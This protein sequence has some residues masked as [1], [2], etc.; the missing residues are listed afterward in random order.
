MKKFVSVLTLIVIVAISLF[1]F[2]A[3][4]PNE[5]DFPLDPPEFAPINIKYEADASSIIPLFKSGTAKF[6]VIGEPAVTQLTNLMKTQNVEV[7]NLFD[8]QALWKSAVNG[9]SEGYPQASVIVK[10]SLLANKTF[11]DALANALSQNAEYMTVNVA[12][13]GETLGTVGSTLAK[14]TFNADLIKRCNLGFTK[15]NADGL[16]KELETYLSEFGFKSDGDKPNNKMPTSDFYYDFSATE[17]ADV[18]QKVTI[19]APDGAPAL[20]LTKII[21]DGKI[22]STEVEVVLTTGENVIAKAKSGE[23]DIAVLPT[24]AA[25]T[26]FNATKGNYKLFSVNVFGVLYVVGTEKITNLS[27]LAGTTVYS[28]GLGNTPEYVFKRVLNKNGLTYQNAD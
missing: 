3:C 19:Y 15:A 2:A 4:Q 28:I 23:A 1:A 27:D 7:Y 14:T 12:T 17:T 21:A 10:N 16:G 22:G 25:A 18:P 11:V 5:N 24:N 9:T 13:V 20:A 26:V 8:L 6:A